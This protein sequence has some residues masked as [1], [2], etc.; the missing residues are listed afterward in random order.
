[1]SI[2]YNFSH[3]LNSNG[4]R[5]MTARPACPDWYGRLELTQQQPTSKP[6]PAR[7]LW[8]IIHEEWFDMHKIACAFNIVNIINML[9]R[10]LRCRTPRRLSYTSNPGWLNKCVSR[11]KLIMRSRNRNR[12]GGMAPCE[13]RRCIR[14]VG[15]LFF[16][17]Q[18]TP[19]Y[20]FSQ[21]SMPQ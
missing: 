14:F 11:Q 8:M 18:R 1:V 5:P 4:G 12:S 21:R 19:G 9:R 17:K 13:K 16:L 3:F 6:T 2:S 7:N 20:I 10:Q 15:R